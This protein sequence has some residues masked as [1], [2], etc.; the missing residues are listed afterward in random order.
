MSSRIASLI[1]TSSLLLS[2]LA[3]VSSAKDCTITSV[4][5]PPLT[6]LGAGSYLGLQGGLYPGG[7][8]TRPTAH[9]SAGLALAQSIVP[10]DTL[11][12][13]D[14][15]NGS[16]VVVS[17]GMSNTNQEFGALIPKVQADPLRH[18]R[19]RL[20]N[21]AQGGMDVKWSANP[22]SAYWDTVTNRLRRFGSSPAQ[23]QVIW[24]KHATSGA[25]GTW[26][27]AVDTFTTRLAASVRNAHDR[28]PNAKLMYLTS[29][30][31]AGYAAGAGANPEPYAHG[32]GFA[33]KRVIESQI[34]GV[35]SLEY[36]PANGP[37]E[38]PWLAWGPY[39]WTDGLNPRADGLTWPCDAFVDDGTHPSTS[40]R[41]AI[42]NAL[43]AFLRTDATS[44]P[45][46]L[47]SSWLD[48]APQASRPTLH[49]APN[50][51]SQSVQLSFAPQRPAARLH[52]HDAAGRLVRTLDL[53]PG[54]TRSDWDLLDQSGAAVNSGVY[55]VR[56]TDT[57]TTPAR[58]VLVQR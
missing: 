35:D 58:L 34:N 9:E 18:P 29:R 40:G 12:N 47:A 1:A 26:N 11:G 5:L 45:W 25:R 53:A 30:V 2:A 41:D 50:P 33:M 44:T 46:Y 43:L 48:V 27:A 8:N 14:W 42:A 54:A 21:C 10:L 38:A 15:I 37:V 39:L 24:M 20:I 4:G 55:W 7:V 6:D 3:A 57:S 52:I 51:A 19:V 56:L 28:L 32:G 49:A 22:T 16:I 17:I 13:P 23:V 31:Y 36:N